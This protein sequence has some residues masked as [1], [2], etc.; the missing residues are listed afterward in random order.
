MNEALMR[1][2]IQKKLELAEQLLEHMRPNLAER[3]KDA[4]T[5]VI[6]ELYKGIREEKET[7][8]EQKKDKNKLNEARI[9]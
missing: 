9:E 3:V 1:K 8:G 6:E 2:I 4:R 7:G 5:L